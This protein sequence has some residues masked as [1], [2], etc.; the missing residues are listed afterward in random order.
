MKD[1]NP[2]QYFEFHNENHEALLNL[3]YTSNWLERRLKHAMAK[4]N[5]SHQ[6]FMVLKVL[7]KPY[8][9]PVSAGFIVDR[10]LNQGANVTKLVDKLEDKKWVQRSLCPD[11]RRQM[12]IVLTEEGYKMLQKVSAD[13]RETHNMLAC[14]SKEEASELTRLMQI[15]REH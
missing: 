4:Y 3:I 7:E 13:V 1:N 12:D 14:L 11:N 10:M 9:N 8:P 15:I 2:L 6:Q 5:L